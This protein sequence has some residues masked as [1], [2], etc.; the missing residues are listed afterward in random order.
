MQSQHYSMMAYMPYNFVASHL[1]FGA[2]GRVKIT[3]PTTAH[4]KRSQQQKSNQ[5]VESLITEMNPLARSFCS[6]TSLI[7]DILPCLLEIIKPNLRPVN[8]QLYSAKEME[9][10]KGLIAVM[11]AYSLNFV[12]DKTQDGQYFYK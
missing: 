11:I 4:E 2:H 3:F 5:L 10:L 8:T 7:Q 1:L 12:Q 6:T 9:D